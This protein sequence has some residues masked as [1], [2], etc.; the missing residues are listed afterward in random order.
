MPELSRTLI[1]L[2]FWLLRVLRTRRRV[3]QPALRLL[4][5]LSQ[6]HLILLLRVPLLLLVRW[7]VHLDFVA[8]LRA[9][10][11]MQL[12]LSTVWQQRADLLSRLRP[13]R[14]SHQRVVLLLLFPLLLR[15][16]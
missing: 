2:L 9:F 10:R 7:H 12:D 1:V 15:L 14:H 3:K 13:H 5:I 11:H 4:L 8:R 16:W 6:H